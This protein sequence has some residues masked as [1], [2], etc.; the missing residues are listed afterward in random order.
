VED[1]VV[2][3][4]ASGWVVASI[5]ESSYISIE[6]ITFSGGDGWE[7]DDYGGLRLSNNDH[8][9]IR[10]CVFQNLPGTALSLNDSEA[11]ITVEHN[12]FKDLR[13]NGIYAGCYDGSCWTQ[14][15]V[16]R[17]NL[18]HQMLGDNSD[19]IELDPG[20]QGN[21][22]SDNIIFAV[23]KKGII[24]DT[25]MSGPANTVE[26]NAIWSAGGPGMMI[27]G[28]SLVRNNL[29]FN[30]NGVGI[31]TE[32]TSQSPL[33]DVVISHNT[34]AATLDRARELKDWFNQNTDGTSSAA[35]NMVLAN[36]AISNPLGYAI[37]FYHA[38]DPT[39][40]YVSGNVVSGLVESWDSTTLTSGSGLQDFSDVEGWDFYPAPGSLLIDGGDT[41]SEAWVPEVDFNGLAREGDGPDVGAYEYYQ[42]GNP[43]W[44][45]QED[46]KE[47]IDHVSNSGEDVGGGCC[48]SKTSGAEALLYLPFLSLGWL[49]RRKR[50]QS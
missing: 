3:Q 35:E 29:I 45:L 9:T 4:L 32:R 34:V 12:E 17:G 41:S 11:S 36:N 46:F 48:K 37:R 44:A 38:D 33:S 19:G 20:G 43:G 14:D 6:K 42:E 27:R 31:Q 24:I 7:S 39:G 10:D 15:S 50:L 28:A 13:G 26:G 21:V 49:N 22:I 25:T 8:I 18:L 2:L 23:T 16:F 40:L 47:T 30:I 5:S 1:G